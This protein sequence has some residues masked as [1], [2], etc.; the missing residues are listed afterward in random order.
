MSICHLLKETNR[1]ILPDDSEAATNQ[2]LLSEVM[3]G[4]PELIALKSDQKFTRELEEY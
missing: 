4:V 2:H 1:I 3:F